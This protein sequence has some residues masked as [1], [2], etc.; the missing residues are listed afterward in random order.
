[1]IDAGV[2]IG[3]PREI[4]RQ[5]VLKTMEGSVSLALKSGKH[6]AYLRNDIT[7]PGWLVCFACLSVC[8]FVDLHMHMHVCVVG[9]FMC[10]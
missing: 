1:M 6:P 3:F 8:G 2:H 10:V 5:L 7:S 4:A 9:I